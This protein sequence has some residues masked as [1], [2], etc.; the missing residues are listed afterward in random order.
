MV[1]VCMEVFGEAGIQSVLQ[2]SVCLR[3]LRSLDVMLVGTH[4]IIIR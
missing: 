2:R 1:R 4:F 3:R